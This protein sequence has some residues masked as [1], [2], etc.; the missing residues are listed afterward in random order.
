MCLRAFAKFLRLDQVVE[1][2]VKIC[3]PWYWVES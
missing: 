3:I 2:P 1:T